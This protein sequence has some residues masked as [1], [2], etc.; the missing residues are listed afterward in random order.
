MPA[1]LLLGRTDIAELLTVDECLAA[2]EAAF[3][4]HVAGQT[5]PPAILG[6]VPLFDAADGALLALMDSQ[7]RPDER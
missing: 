4:A 2:V 7:T 3:R 1:T 6:V 5:L